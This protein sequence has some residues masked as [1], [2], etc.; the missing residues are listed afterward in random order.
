LNA[1]S[2]PKKTSIFHCPLWQL[3]IE[4]IYADLEK[5]FRR[6][7]FAHFFGENSIFPNSFARLALQLNI[8]RKTKYFLKLCHAMCYTE[9][10]KNMRM[11]DANFYV[12]RQKKRTILQLE[13]SE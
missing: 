1:T 10:Y 9:V 3:Q 6:P 12:L 4:L 13:Q 11:A 5:A 2:L 7:P 8:S